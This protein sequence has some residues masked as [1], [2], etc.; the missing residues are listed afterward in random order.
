MLISFVDE[1][2]F[3]VADQL[4]LLLLPVGL[5]LKELRLGLLS[6]LIVE[7]KLVLLLFEDVSVFALDLLHDA[8]LD[9]GELFSSIGDLICAD[10]FPIREL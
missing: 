1:A 8:L 10:G 9:L 5:E 3:I 6:S 4:P 7:L 2:G